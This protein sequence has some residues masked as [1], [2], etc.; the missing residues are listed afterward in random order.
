[1]RSLRT[2]SLL[3]LNQLLP[4]GRLLSATWLFLTRWFLGA[5]C[6]SLSKKAY[7]GQIR[8]VGSE[9]NVADQCIENQL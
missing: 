3:T 4:A 7:R 6:E 1:V 9:S 2:S 5:H 8:R